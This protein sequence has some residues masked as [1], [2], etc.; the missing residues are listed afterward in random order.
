MPLLLN[1]T[2]AVSTGVLAREGR[3]ES[4]SMIRQWETDD[5]GGAPFT[6]RK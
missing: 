2:A 6:R 1:P 3:V 4:A 5:T